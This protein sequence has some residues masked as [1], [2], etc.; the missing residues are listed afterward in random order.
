MY[1]YMYIK[2]LSR[3]FV[4][5]SEG[6]RPLGRPKSRWE[7]NIK[8]DLQEVGLEGVD[9]IHCVMIGTGCGHL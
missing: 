8:L 4:G 1:I 7:N 6:K 5:S 9:W 2:L 3:V